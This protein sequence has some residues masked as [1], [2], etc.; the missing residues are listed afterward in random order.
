[1]RSLLILLLF[2]SGSAAQPSSEV[3]RRLAEETETNLRKEILGKWFPAAVDDKDGGFFQNFSENWSRRSE[4]SRG[5]VY[6]ARLTW[7]AA[8]AATRFP[9]RAPMYLAQTRHGL[10]FLN[11]KLW[12]QKNGGFFWAVYAAG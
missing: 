3:Y 4:S 2:L 1:M 8:Q 5:I 9:D 6:E 10:A 7:T 12:D 11:E